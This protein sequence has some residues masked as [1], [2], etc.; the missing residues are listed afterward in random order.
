[1]SRIALFLAITVTIISPCLSQADPLSSRQIPQ[2]VVQIF[3]Q[4]NPAELDA[5]WIGVGVESTSGSGV[6]I[7][8]N[9]ILTAAHVVD[10]ALSIEI[11]RPGL[12]RRYVARVEQFGHECDLAIL[13]V[14]R[15]EFFEGT[16]PMP[17][18]GTPKVEDE[19]R[20]YGFPVG[21]DA[22][23]V[24]S[25]IVSR[26][27]VSFYAHSM[28]KLLLLQIDAA[29]NPGNSGGPVVSEG[30]LAGISMQLLD[31]A[32]NVG[33]IIPAAVIAHF[34]EDLKEHGCVLGFPSLGVTVQPIT[35]DALRQEYALA[36]EQDGA[37]VVGVNYGD[38]AS[39]H[40]E[41]GDVIIAV[42]G[43]RVA[44]D[45]TVPVDGF[46]RL[47]FSYLIQTK[48]VGEETSLEVLRGGQKRH[49]VISLKNVPSLV[50][51]THHVTNNSFYVFG[52]LVFQP[53]TLEYLFLYD[54]CETWIPGELSIYGL[55]RNFRTPERDQ[56]IM[57]TSVLPAP[58]N[59]GY[60]DYEDEVVASVNG[61]I[62]RDM[63]DLLSIVENAK[64]PRLRILMESGAVLVLD[65]ERARADQGGILKSHRLPSECSV[66]LKEDQKQQ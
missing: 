17:L 28:R 2:S 51:G 57:L 3:V 34:L 8:G 31:G 37:L 44:E 41:P 38:S 40:L 56:V 49:E 24:T 42:D 12:P 27:E 52:G 5:P 60:Q 47:N 16:V 15:E 18:G 14:E 23:S 64:G 4:S 22:L 30:T 35:N 6:I 54:D 66:G 50:P 61:R 62:P 29:L 59:R 25:G 33:Y 10:D 32:E 58:I 7:E 21:G 39:G 55:T 11:K 53:L 26:A 46:G 13:S 9:R 45:L 43:I 63:R 65:L 19:V 48:Q 1:M 36:P 20:V